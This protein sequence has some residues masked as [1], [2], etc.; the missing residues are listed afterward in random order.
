MK[1]KLYSIKDV[2]VGFK[3]MFVAPNDKYA[4]RMLEQLVNDVNVNDIKNSP[5]DYQLF[6]MGEMDDQTGE[7]FTDVQFLANAIDLKYVGKLEE[8]KED[9]V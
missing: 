9:E 3:P 2:L 7:V 4:I 8:V 6:Y 5:K 1:N